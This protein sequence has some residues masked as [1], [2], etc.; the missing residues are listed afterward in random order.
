MEYSTTCVG[1]LGL[2]FVAG[3]VG[4][5][6]GGVATHLGKE[7]RKRQSSISSEVPDLARYGCNLAN[8][9]TQR[10]NDYCRADASASGTDRYIVKQLNTRV[11]SGGYFAGVSSMAK[12]SVIY[13][14]S[15]YA[16]TAKSKKRKSR[17]GD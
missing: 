10:D 4:H 6:G 14:T 11:H 15:W 8:N 7:S 16:K 1:Y 13:Q 17:L 9:G 2:D 12:K 5:Q 3:R